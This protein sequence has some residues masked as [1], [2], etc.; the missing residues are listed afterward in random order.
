[1]AAQT[2]ENDKLRY[3]VVGISHWHRYFTR[4][5]PD[6]IERQFIGIY[7]D[8]EKAR[9]HPNG[10]DVIEC[11]ENEEIGYSVLWNGVYNKVFYKHYPDGKPIAISGMWDD[12][13]VAARE[14]ADNF[15]APDTVVECY[16]KGFIRSEGSRYFR[17][18][19]RST[20]E[21]ISSYIMS[22][23]TSSPDTLD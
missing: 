16:R 11:I 3:G 2:S 10:T 8:K 15:G 23:R 19:T 12:N 20:A 7:K 18:K 4:M 5:C 1:M 14:H 6:G 9:E 13:Y 17:G 22:L 21:M